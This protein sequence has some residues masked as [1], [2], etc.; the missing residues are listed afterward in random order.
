MIEIISFILIILFFVSLLHFVYE[1]AIASTARFHLRN[2]LFSLR[3][4]VRREIMSNNF[5][6]T[7]KQGILFVHDGVSLYINGLP[8]LNFMTLYH[9]S[10]MLKTEEFR[11][12]VEK[13][14]A[15]I[16]DVKNQEVLDAFSKAHG[17]IRRAILWNCGPWLVYILPVTV[18]FFYFKS[19]KGMFDVVSN[20]IISMSPSGASRLRL[21]KAL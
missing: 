15:A 18:A 12:E 5:D 7:E 3:D 6:P 17:A 8:H 14:S 21:S 1:N 10:K 13:R 2:E 16:R 20:Q 19:I 4:K 11:R 9:A